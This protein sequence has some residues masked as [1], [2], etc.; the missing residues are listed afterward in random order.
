MRQAYTTHVYGHITHLS[1][2]HVNLQSEPW[3]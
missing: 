1:G 3:C 2:E